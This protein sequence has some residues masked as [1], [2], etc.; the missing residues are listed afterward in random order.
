MPTPSLP[1]SI[2]Q[3]AAWLAARLA[4]AAESPQFEARLL[5]GH[6]LGQPRAWLQAH[7]EAPLSAQNWNNLQDL[8]ARRSSGEPLPYLLGHWEFY[9]LDLIVTP[10]VLIPRPET[11]LLVEEALGWLAANPQRRRA[12]DVGAGSGCIAASLGCHTIGL[13]ITACDRSAPALEVARRNLAAL[14]LLGQPSGGARLAQADLLEPFAPGC[15][16]L[17]CANLPYIPT[18]TLHSLPIY[19][20]EPTLALDG[21]PDGLD[22]VRRLLSQAAGRLASGGLLLCE[23]EAGQGASALQSARLAFPDARCQ[24]RQDLSHFDRLLV[25]EN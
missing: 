7:P 6:V 9:G 10:D 19:G 11:E 2:A 13:A 18:A 8:A 23:I 20:R 1:S 16:D 15:F 17:I 22:L 4:P 12:A 25:I 24:V 3:A 14:G 5:L 21:G